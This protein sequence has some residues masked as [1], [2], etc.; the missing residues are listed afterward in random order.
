MKVGS[1]Y[2][3]SYVA[4]ITLAAAPFT[5]LAQSPDVQAARDAVKNQIEKVTPPSAKTVAVPA[6]TL[7]SRIA[8]ARSIT[9]LAIAE[10]KDALSE[11]KLAALALS[12]DSYLASVSKALIPR[13]RAYQA[14]A[15]LVRDQLS[16]E[17]LSEDELKQIAASLIQWHESVYGPG[18]RQTLNLSLVDQGGDALRTANKRFERVLADVAVLQ[19]LMGEEAQ[20]LISMLESARDYLIDAQDFYEWARDLF[21]DDQKEFLKNESSKAPGALVKTTFERGDQGNF[22]CAPKE[23]V[24]SCVLAFKNSDGKLYLLIDLAS[25]INSKEIDDVYRVTGSAVSLAPAFER[26]LFIGALFV[27]HVN[28]AASSAEQNTISID[29]TANLLSAMPTIRTASPNVSTLIKGEI[30]SIKKMYQQL[31]EMVTLA[32]KLRAR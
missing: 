24:K 9:D 11:K 32:K 27:E 16:R 26:D 14:Y 8:A 1:A 28:L 10:T 31:L 7:E 21:I 15:Q 22:V 19:R 13:I 12:P 30:E 6:D 3:V 5:A 29:G 18:M 25:T 4:A 23:G 20:Q 17:G 2:I